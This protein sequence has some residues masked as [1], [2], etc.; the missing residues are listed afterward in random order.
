[1]M[2][3]PDLGILRSPVQWGRQLWDRLRGGYW[4]IPSTC[5]VLAV[6]AAFA[7]IAL[8]RYLKERDTLSWT[9]AGG[10]ENASDT[11][12]TIA[13]SMITFTGLVFSITVLALQLTSSQF[14]PRALRNF[15]RDRVAQFSL[16]TFLA[17][18]AYSFAALSAVRVES[19]D[20]P[21]FVPALTVTGA[22][23]LI[24]IS[25]IM[26]V[27][28]I[29]HM[30]QSMRVVT[31]IERITQETRETIDSQYP[32]PASE[33]GQAPAPIADSY[34][35]MH[36]LGAP[37]AG[38]IVDID[39]DGLAACAGGRNA[40]VEVLHPIGTYV[41]E[42]QP[43][44]RVWTPDSSGDGWEALQQYVL[45]DSERTMRNDAAFGFRQLV[46]IAERALSPGVNDPTT[47]I[48]CLDRIHDLLRRLS[49][50]DVP[51]VR[52][53]ELD[54][55]VCASAPSP[56]FDDFVGL[57]TEEIW[58]WG[59]ESLQVQ[60][61]LRSLFDDLMHATTD[62]DRRKCLSVRA[63]ALS[64]VPL[65]LAWPASPST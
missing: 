17:T 31:I 42:G 21:S 62:P 25:L 29:H 49:G 2:Q 3:I 16:G 43:I 15:L 47:A 34:R 23:A 26:F 55:V 41:C 8:D 13:S 53:G 44:M 64:A 32:S 6:A 10:P 39:L 52:F 28:Y 37:G 61:R 9:Y 36:V 11:L 51:P 7:M 19:D 27:E 65:P 50:R 24:G 57:G 5:V 59:R 12:T 38:V 22:F 60:A 4:L 54:G 46:D 58:R 56:S 48:Q 45:R 20:D 14:S 33:S 35:L 18:F 30:A 1:L 63:N 40:G